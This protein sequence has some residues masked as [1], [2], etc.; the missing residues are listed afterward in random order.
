MRGV[1]ISTFKYSK[2]GI[3]NP[4]WP[5]GKKIHLL[6][7]IFSPNI[8]IREFAVE[9]IVKA[10]NFDEARFLGRKKCYDA[11]NLFWFSS[12]VKINL[13][14]SKDKISEEGTDKIQGMASIP[15]KLHISNNT[16]ITMEE[17]TEIENVH[18]TI[19]NTKNEEREILIRSVHWWSLSK[20]ETDNIDCFIKLWISL[21]T[22]FER[23]NIGKKVTN[24][25][26]EIYPKIKRENITKSF[27]P[28]KNIR[29]DIVHEGL[30]NPNKILGYNGKL[31]A[32]LED[33]LSFRLGMNLKRRSE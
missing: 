14:N 1:S 4:K 13:D 12:G 24:E 29:N 31:E 6:G 30:R 7:C 16:P 25:L 15:C 33:I 10:D 26:T 28:I 9:T 17:L 3:I 27:R 32:I 21:E 5:N 11:A 20:G 23:N 19:L 18:K 2:Q 22:L 8:G